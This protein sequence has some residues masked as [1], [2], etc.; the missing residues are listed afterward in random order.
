VITG[1]GRLRTRLALVA[2]LGLTTATVTAGYAFARTGST[3]I[4]TGVVVIDT[5]LAYQDGKAAGTGMVLTSAGEILTNNH[6]IRGATKITVVIPGTG[7]RYAATVVG[8]DVSAD[9][10]VLKANGA[11]NLRTIAVGSSSTVRLGQTVKAVGNAGGT[12]SLAT[13]TGTVTG[14]A[15]TI[16][17]SDEAGGAETLRNLI[18]TNAGLEPGDSGGPLFDTAGKVIGMDTAASVSG[19]FQQVS[20]S[21]GYAIPINRALAIANTIAAGKASATVHIGRTAF[22]GVSAVSPSA[23]AAYGYPSSGAV[24]AAVVPKGPA[25]AAGLTAGDLITSINGHTIVSPAALSAL[26]LGQTPGTTITVTYRD[27]AGTRHTVRA[28]LASGPPQ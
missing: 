8:Y 23:V 5:N 28:I 25:A 21:D 7:R 22:L 18:E 11:A 27:A 9:V 26:V 4:G 24:V 10:A 17:V 16:T 13:A 14:V 1:L 19:G 12:G 3:P 6:V 2:A 15:R 20:S